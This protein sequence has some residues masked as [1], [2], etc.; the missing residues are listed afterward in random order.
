MADGTVRFDGDFGALI[1]GLNDVVK[2]MGDLRKAAID[3]KK[4]VEKSSEGSSKA[5]VAAAAAEKKAL[6]EATKAVVDK[7][8]ATKLAKE[9]EKRAEKSLA[10]ERAL[11]LKR[12]TADLKISAAQRIASGKALI[13]SRLA[14]EKER[15]AK[16]QTLR[17]A[18]LAAEAAEQKVAGAERLVR[19]KGQNAKE[20]ALVKARAAEKRAA[21]EKEIF[22]LKQAERAEIRAAK[23]TKQAEKEKARETKKASL[24]ITKDLKTVRKSLND[25]VI[26]GRRAGTQM[27]VAMKQVSSGV[28][29]AVRG[30]RTDV[31]SLQAAVALGAT[32]T[33]GVAGVKKSADFETGIA[34]IATIL[35]EGAELDLEK[36]R[37]ALLRLNE[38]SAKD[39]IDLTDGLRRTITGLPDE[40]R[41]FETAM[42]LLTQATKA[43]EAGTAEVSDTVRGFLT[44]LNA[45][46]GVADLTATEVRD[47]LFATVRLGNL[48]FK[49]LASS[50]GRTA[51]SAAKFGI[52]ADELLAAT[53]T[54]TTGGLNARQ[55][56]VSLTGLMNAFIK[57]GPKA[58][59]AFEDAAEASGHFGFE[60]KASTLK[61]LGL[62]GVL[63]IVNKGL[64]ENVDGL[65][66][67]VRNIRGMRGAAGLLGNGYERFRKNLD[68]VT[69]STGEG[70]RALEKFTGTTERIA[71]I[72]GAKLTTALVN[73][74][75]RILPG[76]KLKLTELGNA[77]IENQGAVAD[78]IEGV[79]NA[80]V[81]LS[82]WVVEN[83]ESLLKFFILV[84]A[85]PRLYAFIKGIGLVVLA[86][87]RLGK[88]FLLLGAQAGAGG[89]ATG[90]AFIAGLKASLAG[91]G[92]AIAVSLLTAQGL[93]LVAAGTIAAAVG[94]AFTVAVVKG[95]E[96]GVLSSQAADKLKAQGRGIAKE[97]QERDAETAALV[98]QK[99]LGLEGLPPSLAGT[100]LS[101]PSKKKGGKD[102]DLD[103]FEAAKELP[104]E[105]FLRRV[106]DK[107][108]AQK[109]EIKAELLKTGELFELRRKNAEAI[110]TEQGLVDNS[111][112]GA[113]EEL[114]A[115]QQREETLTEQFR[116]AG[117]RVV[118]LRKSQEALEGLAPIALRRAE[119]ERKREA[120]D[121]AFEDALAKG[122]AR[123]ARKKTGRKGRAGPLGPATTR[124]DDGKA[125]GRENIRRQKAIL[126]AIQAQREAELD[127][128]EARNEADRDAH[129]EALAFF[130]EQVGR[131]EELSEAEILGLEQAGKAYSKF[132]ADRK[133]A[134]DEELELVKERAEDEKKVIEEQLEEKLKLLKADEAGDLERFKQANDLKAHLAVNAEKRAARLIAAEKKFSR[135]KDAD[136]LKAFRKREEELRLKDEVAAAEK[137]AK[138]VAAKDLSVELSQKAR[139]A[140]KKQQAAIDAEVKI[141]QEVANA[142]KL[143]FEREEELKED[144][145]RIAREEIEKGSTARGIERSTREAQRFADEK[146]GGS[147]QTA[148]TLLGG[149]VAGAAT[150]FGAGSGA[151]TAAGATAAGLAGSVVPYIAIAQAIKGLLGQ[152]AEFI[153]GGGLD[154]WLQEFFDVLDEALFAIVEQIP[155][156]F[157]NL[158]TKT[159]P[160]WISR[161]LGESIPRLIVSLH[162]DFIPGLL[163]GLFIGLPMILQSVVEGIL[164]AIG[165]LGIAIARAIFAGA[166]KILDWFRGDS[167][168]SD[169]RGAFLP[170][171][172]VEKEKT[173]AP[174]TRHVGGLVWDESKEEW[175]P[176]SNPRGAARGVRRLALGG[177]IRS[178][179][180]ALSA[181]ATAFAAMGAQR[182]E[183]GGTVRGLLAA[184]LGKDTEPALLSPGEGV[185]NRAAM[186]A[187]GGEAGLDALNRGGPSPAAAAP[188]N[189]NVRI[190]GELGPLVNRVETAV[191]DPRGQ[192]VRSFN[193]R[194]RVPLMSSVVRRT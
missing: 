73:I 56:F 55:A 86:L 76:V 31:T 23:I 71:A 107:L 154:T 113:P 158:M 92:K 175:V 178:T 47:K 45:Y 36:Y 68:K 133:A 114:A 3:S 98:A 123:A 93:I 164:S 22:S 12:E 49:E 132:L 102:R 139:A 24:Q 122:N 116:L 20:I 37:E 190:G 170:G 19:L 185:L 96:A 48:D 8:A 14:F 180:S 30:V 177:A 134:L 161:F 120:D 117:Q 38:V 84:F 153:T 27:T 125:I 44:V 131:V 35:P 51:G 184:R 21:H 100:I 118:A 33:I 9:E 168:L 26:A 163:E 155:K 169:L 165:N 179:G 171:V 70:D 103:I 150:V 156:N 75:D 138:L 151:A 108:A 53:A 11:G 186:A 124:V 136:K 99:K 146:F 141:A 129:A 110:K 28:G 13:E 119:E 188:G 34:K 87:G 25:M 5:V 83:R 81:K 65:A 2:A 137:R 121:A 194:R 94:V 126:D 85:V 97:T 62:A 15:I 191:M 41:S 40:V 17:K 18:E 4:D 167:F 174:P 148:Q 60:A 46:R 145:R 159:L 147:A 63:E 29:K 69:N 6:G 101:V 157:V 72:L 89:A 140:A 172:G 106:D 54:L 104:Q 128:R 162:T 43:A 193:R 74:G 182:F 152:L 16:E 90:L 135:K 64:S 57:A 183:D 78:A 187:I 130:D 79:F 142:D 109:G 61:Q 111:T 160:E 91:V 192:V 115:L 52:T 10:H 143:R 176:S 105:D 149:T 181:T 58:R 42:D 173:D 1:K 88:A 7:A 66:E 127:M 82:T 80:L 67:A 50:I 39:L 77:I 189:I 32:T 95:I 112:I 166:N 144:S 59:A